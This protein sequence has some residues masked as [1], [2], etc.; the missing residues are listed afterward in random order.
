[1]EAGCVFVRRQHRINYILG[2]LSLRTRSRHWPRFMAS[3]FR[4]P[5][6]ACPCSEEVQV[7]HDPS[8]DDRE[9]SCEPLLEI[10][11]LYGCES[12]K[13]RLDWLDVDLIPR[14]S[15]T[16]PRSLKNFKSITEERTQLPQAGDIYVPDSFFGC[17]DSGS[18]SC[19][20]R[21]VL[22]PLRNE[23]VSVY[24]WRGGSHV[25]Y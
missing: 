7:E 10:R 2:G 24:R 17:L 6:H 19:S 14:V 1:M 4:T 18:L 23:R 5:L 20:C 22:R 3:K 12:L 25:P 11:T 13:Q 15:E 21:C 8:L 16:P 9:P